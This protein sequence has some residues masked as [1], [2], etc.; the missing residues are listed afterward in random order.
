MK[1]PHCENKSSWIAWFQAWIAWFQAWI[2]WNQIWIAWFQAFWE[3]FREINL[4]ISAWKNWP[5][6][7]H[8]LLVLMLWKIVKLS[9]D[10]IKK[11]SW[12]QSIHWKIQLIQLVPHQ[13]WRFWK[14]WLNSVTNYWNK[15]RKWSWITWTK[16]CQELHRLGIC[17]LLLLLFYIAYIIGCIFWKWDYY[18][19]IFIQSWKKYTSSSMAQ[20]RLVSRETRLKFA[21]LVSRDLGPRVSQ[22]K[23]W[24]KLGKISHVQNWFS[25]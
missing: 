17:F 9:L 23:I 12:W 5:K 6:D 21:R 10:Y 2:A 18:P 3:F 22:K 15:T 19:K 20:S 11:E 25:C 4:F 8:S 1:F 16:K 14:F 13:I 7:S 24:Q